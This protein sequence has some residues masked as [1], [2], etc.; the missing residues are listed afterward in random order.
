MPPDT[1]HHPKI[2]LGPLFKVL[3]DPHRRYTMYHLA[4]MD[5]ETVDLSKLVAALS[6]RV[7]IS[8]EQLE[9][10]L[11]HIHLP[12]LADHNLIEY[13]E[14][15][16]TIRYRDGERVETVLEFAQSEEEL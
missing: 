12:K 8:P 10:D 16:E 5:G 6:E 14:R 4:T 11:R 3:A 7:A 15:S 9:I 13:D 2:S 1:A